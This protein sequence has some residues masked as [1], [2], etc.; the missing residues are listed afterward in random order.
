MLTREGAQIRRVERPR[1]TWTVEAWSANDPS[2]RVGPITR[3]LATTRWGRL[4]NTLG[5]IAEPLPRSVD[6]FGREVIDACHQLTAAEGVG[7]DEGTVVEY[8][9]TRIGVCVCA[10]WSRRPM[11]GDA[12]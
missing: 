6:A 7:G 9:V 11:R 1:D 4:S 8:A 12:K 10:S 3:E 2:V 5:Y